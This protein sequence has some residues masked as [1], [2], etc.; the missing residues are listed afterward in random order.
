M[1]IESELPN[2]ELVN[3]IKESRKRGYD[4]YQI[5]D[6][7]LKHKWPLTE[8][9]D[10]F[11]FLKPKPKF[12]NK[13]CIYLDSDV[14][15]AL[16]KRANKNMFTISEQIEDILRRSAINSSKMKQQSEKLDDMLVSL[17]SRKNTGPKIKK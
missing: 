3:F 6:A 15:K 11:V 16:D 14:L 12:K 7:L 9:E 17:F 8:I 5:K 10:C 4:D 2:K 1:K 13:V